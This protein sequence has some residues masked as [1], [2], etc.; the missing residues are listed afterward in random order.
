LNSDAGQRIKV[1][2]LSGNPV[3][4]YEF[5]DEYALDWL[6]VDEAEKMFYGLS[7]DRDSIYRFAYGESS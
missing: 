4:Q 3:S 2:D 5:S 7:W 1:M 6:V